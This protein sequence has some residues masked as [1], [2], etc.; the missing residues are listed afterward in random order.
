MGEGNKWRW[1]VG[2]REVTKS[3]RLNSIL[4]GDSVMRCMR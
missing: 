3:W 1:G 4:D 2:K